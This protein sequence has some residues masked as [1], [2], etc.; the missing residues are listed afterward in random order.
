MSSRIAICG[1]VGRSTRRTAAFGVGA[2]VGR[3]LEVRLGRHL[4]ELYDG[5]QLVTSHARVERGRVTR[6]EHYPP[7]GQAFLQGTPKACLER[8]DALG[9]AVGIVASAP[10]TPYSL[11]HLR[12]VQA[13]VRLEEQYPAERI[14]RACAKALDAGDGRYRTIRRMLE[15]DLD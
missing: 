1:R 2:Y 15:H 11:T 10:L 6:I 13:L 5:A 3:R 7:A 12:E 9:R 8:A 14:D 4:V